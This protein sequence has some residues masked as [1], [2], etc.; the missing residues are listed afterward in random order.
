MIEKIIN[1]EN[2]EMMLEN[3]CGNVSGGTNFK[4][5]YQIRT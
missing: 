2:I 5:G 3:S 1:C 4:W